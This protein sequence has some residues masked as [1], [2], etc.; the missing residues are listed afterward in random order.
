[1]L[2]LLTRSIK[3][4]VG[5]AFAGV[6][7]IALWGTIS[8]LIKEPPKPTAEEEFHQHPKELHLA[9]DGPFGK[10]DRRQLQRGLKVYQEVCSA[11]HSLSL[12]SFREFKDLGYTDAEV[13]ALAASWKIEQPSINPDTGEATT[14]K[15]VPSDR[16]PAPFANEAAARAANNNAVPP[17]LSLITKARHGGAAYIYSLLTGYQNQPAELVEKFPAVKTPEGLHYNP[18]FANLNLAMPEPLT[19]DGQVEYLD[20]TPNTKDQ[21]AQDVA[22]FLVW[23]AEP[24]ME[25]R[26]RAG[27]AVV[28]FLL[29][30]TLLA[31]GAYRTVWS[32]MKH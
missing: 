23:T 12:V 10:F 26:H 32:G 25:T 6:L 14:R 3:F 16:I 27:L 21:M 17:D 5:I 1:M 11:C 20:G 18:Y 2:P 31:F 13:K 24:T 28:L 19:A 30:T 9:S 15:N 4:L 8:G 29:L 7:M 22:A